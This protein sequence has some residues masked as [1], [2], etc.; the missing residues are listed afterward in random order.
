MGTRFLLC[1]DK[2]LRPNQK[3]TVGNKTKVSDM[4][5]NQGQ[6]EEPINDVTN[7]M[8]IMMSPGTYGCHQFTAIQQQQMAYLKNQNRSQSLLTP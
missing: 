8:M 2:L 1:K 4:Q 7:T 3:W 6:Q 5:V